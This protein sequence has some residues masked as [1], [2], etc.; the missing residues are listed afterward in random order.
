MLLRSLISRAVVVTLSLPAIGSTVLAAPGEVLSHQKISGTEGGF[1][2]VLDDFDNLGRA[3]TSVGDLDGDGVVDVAVGAHRDDDGGM[4][5]GAVWILFL[6]GDGTVKS[7]QKISDT[8]GGFTGILDDVDY[9]GLTVAGL[10]DLDGDGVGDLAVG[11]G[12]DDDGG[13]ER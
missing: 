1:T 6:N 11:E 9:F 2:G 10:G 3:V 8:E 4:D 7:Q 13:T 12:V 5:R